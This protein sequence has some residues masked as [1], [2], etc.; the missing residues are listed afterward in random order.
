MV[1]LPAA[2]ACKPRKYLECGIFAH[3]FARAW[4]DD[5]GN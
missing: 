5:C 1:G 4:C 3:G 2:Q